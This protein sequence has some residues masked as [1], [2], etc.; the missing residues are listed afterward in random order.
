MAGAGTAELFVLLLV[1]ARLPTGAHAHSAGL[2]PLLLASPDGLTTDE[3]AA[4]A[5]DRLRTVAAVEAATAVLATRGDDV[6]GLVDAWAARTPSPA[7][8]DASVRLGRGYLRLARRLWPDAVDDTLD[9]A[10]RAVVAGVMAGLAGVE[11]LS[12]A[13][14][15]LFEDVQSVA[16]AALKLLPGDPVETV[17]WTAGLHARIDE[18][19]R[20]CAAVTST[21]DLPS[22]GAPRADELAE[23]HRSWQRRLFHA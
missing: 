22:A 3:L 11:P 8:R 17:A 9:G 6:A 5:A 4:F 23:R 10:P 12:L 13:R 14:A 18:V 7:V 1:D 19:A 16:S 20:R 21:E 15:L 2:E